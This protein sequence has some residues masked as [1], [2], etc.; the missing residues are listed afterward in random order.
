MSPALYMSGRP[1]VVELSMIGSVTSVDFNDVSSCS[2]QEIHFSSLKT[3]GWWG[4]LA[5][6]HVP[7]DTAKSGALL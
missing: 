3:S 2:L 7:R 6:K 4:V 5:D 1:V